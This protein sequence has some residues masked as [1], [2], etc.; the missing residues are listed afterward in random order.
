[1]VLPTARTTRGKINNRDGKQ[2]RIKLV[3]DE[4]QFA[5]GERRKQLAGEP[6]KEQG[7]TPS[8]RPGW[9]INTL[10][11]RAGADWK[12]APAE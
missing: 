7:A 11:E 6:K 3:V 8:E 1:L 4:I 10:S 12:I 2:N 5:G 9:P